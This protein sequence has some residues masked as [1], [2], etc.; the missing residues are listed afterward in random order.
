MPNKKVFPVEEVKE[1]I[2]QNKTI[3]QIANHFATSKPTMR[4]FFQ[5]NNLQTKLS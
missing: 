2:D 5:E 4:R 1:L 3:E